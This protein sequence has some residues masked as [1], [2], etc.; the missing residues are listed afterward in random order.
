MSPESHL[1]PGKTYE[2]WYGG[3]ALMCPG[4]DDVHELVYCFGENC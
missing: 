1:P 4:S 2:Q 3:F